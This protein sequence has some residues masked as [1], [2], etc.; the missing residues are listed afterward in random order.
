MR[1]DAPSLLTSLQN[2]TIKLVRSLETKKGRR[3]SGLFLAEGAKFAAAAR[4][5]GWRPEILLIDAAALE[6]RLIAGLIAWARHE[7]AR[8][9]AAPEALLAKVSSRDNPQRALAVFA[10]AQKTLDLDDPALARPRATLVVLEEV[11][12]PGNLGT[13]IRTAD[14]AG[15]AGVILVGTCCDPMARESVRA[16]MGSIFAVPVLQLALGDLLAWRA[17]WPGRLVGAHLRGEKDFRQRYA[18]PLAIVMGNEGGGLSDAL[19]AACDELVRI[20]MVGS[21]DSLNLAV[22]TALMVYEAR[23]ELLRI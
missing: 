13:I 19:A 20:P 3:E 16:T 22:A 21:A 12:D 1:G 23:R 17:R 5:Q 11:R 6:D 9:F 4:E 18:G 7:G 2:P 14:A 8:V 15:A 10:E